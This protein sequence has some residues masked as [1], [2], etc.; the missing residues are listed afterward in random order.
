LRK[1]IEE[2]YTATKPRIPK[3]KKTPIPTIE[4][5]SPPPTPAEPLPEEDHQEEYP[6]TWNQVL[7][8]VKECLPFGTDPGRSTGTKLLRLSDVAVIGVPD[9]GNC[10][11][12]ER[13]LY[14]EISDA[15]KEVIGKHLDLQFQVLRQNLHHDRVVVLPGKAA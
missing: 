15:V 9:Q 1:A 13:K 4:P 3:S 11:H 10:L 12:L 2:D 6:E 8:R 5:I 7:D 14:R